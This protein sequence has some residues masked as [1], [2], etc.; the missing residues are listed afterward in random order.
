MSGQAVADR[1]DRPR[2]PSAPVRVYLDSKPVTG[3]YEVRLVAV[4]TRDV[5]A[6]ELMLGDKKLAFGATVVGQRR[7]LVTRIS[8][9]G[10]EGLDVIGSAS[11][12]GRNKVTSLRVGTQP[13]QRKRSTTIRT[14]PDGREIQEVR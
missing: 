12:D 2:K 7:E 13:A 6:I 9:R 1:A 4:P 8:V 11:A 10:G 5:P 14:L 3:G